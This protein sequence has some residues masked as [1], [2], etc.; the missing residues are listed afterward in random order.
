MPASWRPFDSG[1]RFSCALRREPGILRTSTSKVSECAGRTCRNPSSGRLECPTDRTTVVVWASTST[2]PP[3][4][5]AALTHL[6][7]RGGQVARVPIGT[8]PALGAVR[9][10]EV[11]G[12]QRQELMRGAGRPP[13]AHPIL[14]SGFRPDASDATVRET[15]TITHAPCFG[16]S[17]LRRAVAP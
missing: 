17:L 11:F 15:D 1:F 13:Y 4:R 10:L 9:L 6:R 3:G 12:R 14:P 2:R 8:H 5:G 16:Y 7:E